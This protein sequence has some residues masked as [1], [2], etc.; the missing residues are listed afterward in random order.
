MNK[1]NEM[2]ENRLAELKSKEAGYLKLLQ[3]AGEAETADREAA[4]EHRAAAEAT[5]EKLLFEAGFPKCKVRIDS[6]FKLTKAN[7]KF[8]A[9]DD[10]RNT[11]DVDFHDGKAERFATTSVSATGDDV[12]RCAVEYAAYYDVVSKVLEKISSKYTDSNLQTFYE[13]LASFKELEYAKTKELNFNSYELQKQLR[14]VKEEIDHL[15]IGLYAGNV[16]MY[17]DEPPYRTRWNRRSE[18]W[19]KATIV[20]VTSKTVTLRV[21]WTNSKGEEIVGDEA[22]KKL[23]WSKFKKAV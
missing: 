23:D 9:G 5:L 21:H 1:E 6:Y 12:M 2:N 7:V 3:I 19:K 15:E 4:T 8:F 10:A 22:N 16:V 11:F 13:T 20:K 18:F 17:N 14:E